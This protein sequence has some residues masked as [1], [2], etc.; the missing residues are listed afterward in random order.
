[1]G[2]NEREHRTKN[3]NGFKNDLWLILICCSTELLRMRALRRERTS[4]IDNLGS[5]Q[6]IPPSKFLRNPQRP[7]VPEPRRYLNRP[8]H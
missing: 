8:I 6:I 5:L 2:K 3:K 4:E 1:M 7:T